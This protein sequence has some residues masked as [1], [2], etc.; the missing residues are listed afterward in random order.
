MRKDFS[1]P[2]HVG[3]LVVK[4]ATCP[5]R[6]FRLQLEPLSYCMLYR[7]LELLGTAKECT[8]SMR[9][10]HRGND[11]VHQWSSKANTN[12]L[13]DM[14]WASRSSRDIAILADCLLLNHGF[15]IPGNLW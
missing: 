7:T 2:L 11:P 9:L 10:N 6:R 14:G 5:S 4:G 15:W 1:R 3:Q 12:L 13:A 8:W